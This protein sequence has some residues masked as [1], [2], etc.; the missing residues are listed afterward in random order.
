MSQRCEG[1]ASLPSLETPTPTSALLLPWCSLLWPS[2]IPNQVWTSAVPWHCT[3][4]VCCFRLAQASG[5][6]SST[7]SS[8][9]C[10]RRGSASPLRL[11]LRSASAWKNTEMSA[12][13]LCAVAGA[14]SSIPS[15]ACGNPQG[16]LFM[17]FTV[18][19]PLILIGS[20]TFCSSVKETCHQRRAAV[21]WGPLHQENADCK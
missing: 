16:S 4:Y 18:Q 19:P 10:K 11:G 3:G 17:C 14:G 9:M 21:P 6:N 5:P 2:A 13:I 20:V 15:P 7:V 8:V 12:K 1:A